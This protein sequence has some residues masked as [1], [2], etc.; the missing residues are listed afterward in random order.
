V[1]EDFEESDGG[2]PGFFARHLGPARNANLAAEEI[3][4]IA[5]FF[6]SLGIITGIVGVTIY[7][8]PGSLGIGLVLAVA[9]LAL[10][11]SKSRIS[12][13]ILLGFLLANAL[14]HLTAP[15]FWLWAAVALRAAQLAFG[16]QR[17]RPSR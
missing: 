14:L 15:F 2:L 1:F 17:L 11:L 3:H 12:A 10:Y 6:I 8:N 16:Y 7:D 9:A 4:R 5:L 13:L